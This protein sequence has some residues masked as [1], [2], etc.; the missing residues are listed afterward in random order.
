[1]KELAVGVGILLLLGRAGSSGRLEGVVGRHLDALLG[2][3]ERLVVRVR[4]EPAWGG[5]S[6]R[7]RVLVV[8]ASGFSVGRLRFQMGKPGPWVGHV[9][10]FR[11]VAERFEVGGVPLRLLEVE[12]SGMRY[13][14]GAAVRGQVLLV[15]RGGGIFRA[16]LSG[17][18][19]TRYVQRRLGGGVSVVLEPGHIR[20]RGQV[21]GLF[22]LEW[23]A[24][25]VVLLR[26]GERV[27]WVPE[28]I[29]A[30]GVEVPDLGGA[31]LEG[32][33]EILDVARDFD[34]GVPL[35]LGSVQVGVDGVCLSGTVVLGR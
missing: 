11:M 25:G 7:I 5:V 9:D 22:P 17:G 34:F 32:G 15:A 18:D 10:R 23:E 13:D 12:L 8:R 3:P 24:Q 27:V 30:G 29:R 2:R 26:G 31:F 28:W 33:I 1:M 19:L 21:A 6:G 14:L 16:E 20:V 35:M 4:T